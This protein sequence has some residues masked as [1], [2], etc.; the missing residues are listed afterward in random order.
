MRW[1]AL[2]IGIILLAVAAAVVVIILE[3]TD[4]HRYR[5]QI[6]HQLSRALGREVQIHGP[7]DLQI[8]LVPTVRVEDVTLANA[9]GQSPAEMAKIGHLWLEVD[10]WELLE[11]EIEF[12]DL[13]VR[14]AE[15]LL[16]WSQEGRPNW[17]SSGSTPRDETDSGGLSFELHNLEIENLTLRLHHAASGSRRTARLE[18]LSLA[19]EGDA[20]EIEV[21]AAGELEGVR[22]DLSGTTGTV[23]DLVSGKSISPIDLKGEVFDLDVEVSGTIGGGKQRGDF[24]LQVSASAPESAPIAQRIGPELPELGPIQGSGK[25]S[26]KA[27]AVRL[28]EISLEVGEHQTTGA[29][30]TGE[31]GDLLRL[32][33][34]DLD[35]AFR[36]ES[37]HHLSPLVGQ[38]P[39]EIGAVGGTA[40]LN[41]RDGT[42]GI[43]EFGLHGGHQEVLRIEVT[44]AL[45][46]LRSLGEIGVRGDLQ[47]KDLSVIGALFDAHLPPIGP[48]E[49]SGRVE[50]SRER[51][52]IRAMRARLDK[53][54]FTGEV[55]GSF[56]SGSRPHLTARLESPGIHLEDVGLAP[57][58]EGEAESSP[59]V[60]EPPESEALP[61]DRLRGLDADL[62]LQAAHVVG[63]DDFLVE[64]M[65]LT[66][67]LADGDLALGPVTLAFEGGSFTGSARINARSDPPKLSLVLQGIDM[68]LGTALAQVQKRPVATGI[69]DLSLSLESRGASVEALRAALG[70]DASLAIR[71]GQLYVKRMGLIAQDVFGNLYGSV[72]KGVASTTR[73]IGGGFTPATGR[74]AAAGADT[75]PI[76]CFAA[77]LEIV[78]GVA[79]A[80]VLALDTGEM[81]MLGRGRV[82]LVEERYDI[83]IEPKLKRRSLLTVTI[84]LDIH[85]P[86]SKPKVSPD[87]LGATEN[88]ATDFF[89]NLVRPGAEILPFVE[90]GLW[91][92]KSCADLRE[93]L[94]R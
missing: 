37:L 6:A 34:V 32:R 91:D 9:P 65:A 59:P 20:E 67:K 53:T 31:I 75:K 10:L 49:I 23:S 86:L 89:R 14:D 82:D 22:F 27:G 71:E 46:D 74:Q 66:L 88:T 69:A 1:R 58:G 21:A 5:S 11:G 72:R 81:V 47:A 12:R 78:G 13:R 63:R 77:D 54:H 76:Q 52:K 40:R 8:G 62:S 68:N 38:N 33:G 85:G 56:A 2:V 87:L 36:A 93:E 50:G 39:P 26:G 90:T 61:F 24:D 25:L 41:D 80:R 64:E 35:L 70:G 79:T 7:L 48:V 42:L 18:H 57:R 3:Q 30:L 51:A 29:K 4:F 94:Y 84:P 60:A 16:Q 17:P 44:G 15:I 83:H 43:E 28:S 92:Q 45:D 19:S 73:K 55:E